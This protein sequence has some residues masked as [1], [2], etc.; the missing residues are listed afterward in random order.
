MTSLFKNVGSLPWKI[1]VSLYNPITLTSFF[2]PICIFNINLKGLK[3]ILLQRADENPAF[4]DLNNLV[5]HNLWTDAF[6]DLNV[7]YVV[8]FVAFVFT[9]FQIFR[10]TWDRAKAH[11]LEAVGTKLTTKR[12]GQF[13]LA[14]STIIVLGGFALF[15]TGILTTPE[16][17]Q[18][19]KQNAEEPL[20]QVRSLG[21]IHPPPLTSY[22]FL[23]R[24]VLTIY[25]AYLTYFFTN[26][27]PKLLGT[28]S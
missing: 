9:I 16:Q 14:I 8:L 21:G 7:Q 17:I 28:E 11:N 10:G 12:H 27:F 19:Y 23:G 2:A 20:F 5:N 26:A 24:T 15:M 22:I 18:L 6:T 13:Y 4:R 3:L 25:G 1:F